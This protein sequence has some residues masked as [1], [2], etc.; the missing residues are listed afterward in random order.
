[1]PK[2][3]IEQLVASSTNLATAHA[4]GRQ[5]LEIRLHGIHVNNIRGRSSHVKAYVKVSVD[6]Y[7]E[8][9]KTRLMPNNLSPSWT[10]TPP[11]HIHV[12]PSSEIKFSLY[13]HHTLKHNT[14]IGD[15][16]GTAWTLLSGEGALFRIG[17]KSPGPTMQVSVSVEETK[18]NFEDAPAKL[19]E[20]MHQFHSKSFRTTQQLVPKPMGRFF[21]YEDQVLGY[22]EVVLNTLTNLSPVFHVCEI[23]VA[24]VKIVRKVLKVQKE[25]DDA[26]RDMFQRLSEVAAKALASCGVYPIPGALLACRRIISVAGK[27]AEIIDRWFY[28]AA[29]TRILMQTEVRREIKGFQDELE[30]VQSGL[31]FNLDLTL[32]QIAS[33]NRLSSPSHS[34]AAPVPSAPSYLVAYA[35]RQNHRVGFQTRTPNVRSTTGSTV[36]QPPSSFLRSCKS[37]PHLSPQYAPSP[38]PSSQ[39]TLYSGPPSPT[40]STRGWSLSKEPFEPSELGLD[41]TTLDNR[42]QQGSPMDSAL[43]HSPEEIV[44]RPSKDPERHWFP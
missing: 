18:A 8:I 26:I 30:E 22:V 32:C 3:T 4:I 38:A 9:Y 35:S 29:A 5:Q 28:S 31:R 11:I 20:M 33:G 24:L 21:E 14:H 27:S 37:V 44:V 42:G 36:P 40:T 7:G 13:V 6:D 34:N 23:A 43:P 2:S 1:M 39:S 25:I 10:F 15:L 12:Y 19:E 41:L 17:T 16:V